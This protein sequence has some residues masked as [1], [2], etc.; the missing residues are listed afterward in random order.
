MR[1][2]CKH[3]WEPERAHLPAELDAHELARAVVAA[4]AAAAAA[5]QHKAHVLE[6]AALLLDH[7]LDP[8]V[9]ALDVPL[10]K[11]THEDMLKA[12]RVAGAVPAATKQRE[13]AVQAL[14]ETPAALN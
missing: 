10:V 11:L 8:V 5:G 6:V 7:G 14:D 4:A 13:L 12:G 3:M 1:L 2:L 9:Q